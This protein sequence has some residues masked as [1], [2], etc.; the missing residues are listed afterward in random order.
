MAPIMWI[1]GLPLRV[2]RAQWLAL[3]SR[4]LLLLLATFFFISAIR[5]MPQALANLLS[6]EIAHSM[7]QV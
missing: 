2:T 1:M 7:W 5:V 4:A 6:A 3:V